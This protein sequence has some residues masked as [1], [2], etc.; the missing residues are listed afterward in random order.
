MPDHSI[1]R[2][3]FARKSRGHRFHCSA[4]CTM[5]ANGRG[6]NC[7]HASGWPE[8]LREELKEKFNLTDQELDE[9]TMYLL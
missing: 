6:R 7:P 5:L 8:Q 1:N 2:Y 3:R 4:P 9:L